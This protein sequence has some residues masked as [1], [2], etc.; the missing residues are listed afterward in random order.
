MGSRPLKTTWGR[1]DLLHTLPWQVLEI[2]DSPGRV[3]CSLVR[4]RQGVP[5]WQKS[6]LAT[7]ECFNKRFKRGNFQIMLVKGFSRTNGIFKRIQSRIILKENLKSLFACR[8]LL[9]LP[10]V[11]SGK[12][13]RYLLL[14][15]GGGPPPGL[16]ALDTVVQGRPIHRKPMPR[17][18]SR[19]TNFFWTRRLSKSY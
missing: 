12:S 15:R 4:F 6:T 13:H 17:D 14:R 3:P 16:R 8:T 18:F 7:S 2:L 19:R 10:P 1:P 11:R 9:R 5:N